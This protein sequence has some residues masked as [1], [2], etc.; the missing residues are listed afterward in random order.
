MTTL[1]LKKD[2]TIQLYDEFGEPESE[3]TLPG[4]QDINIIDYDNEKTMDDVH[5]ELFKTYNVQLTSEYGECSIEIPEEYV[6]Y[7]K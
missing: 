7:I 3:F 5:S 2:W 1:R 6:E 4:G